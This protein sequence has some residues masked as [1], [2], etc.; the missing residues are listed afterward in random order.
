MDRRVRTGCAT[1]RKRRVKCDE[2]RPVCNRCRTANFVCEG[3]A[4][5][6]QAPN[7]P[8]LAPASP[9]HDT[10]EGSSISELS[11]RHTNWRQEQLPLYHHFVT[12]TVVRLFRQDHISFWRDQ[13]AQMSYGLDIV[14]EALLAIGAMHR[15]SLLTC[16]HESF[17]EATK[18]R[19]LGLRAYGNALRLLPSHLT[20]HTVA[21]I[22]A[23]LIVLMLLTYFEVRSWFFPFFRPC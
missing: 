15:S 23:A 14:Y 19:V 2:A 8:L 5:P 22:L 10:P 11:W 4:P 6:R 18:F 1:C 20:Q 7:A 3:Y 16:Q 12:T 13:V 17:Q 21:D 9:R